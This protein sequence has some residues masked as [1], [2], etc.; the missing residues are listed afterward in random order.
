MKKERKGCILAVRMRGSAGLRHQVESVLQVLGLTRRNEAILLQ[1]TP[2]IRGT[3]TGLKDV[4]FWGEASE[5]ILNSILTSRSKVPGLGR[6]TDDEV[7]K[8]L[9]IENIK[10]L[11][12]ALTSG[13]LKPQELRKR[14]LPTKFNLH[15]PKGG[16]RGSLKDPSGKGGELG[17]KGE[18][19][20]ETVERMI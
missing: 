20:K 8:R 2:E 3:L 6:L 12:K 5:E 19:F 1:D 7:K 17:Y 18:S 4:I 14:D 15:P 10:T 13:E 11:A 16:F 9:G